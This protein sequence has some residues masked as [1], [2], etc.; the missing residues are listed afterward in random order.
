MCAT[1]SQ[2]AWLRPPGTLA[3]SLHAAASM[4]R[5]AILHRPGCTK[6]NPVFAPAAVW[7]NPS[8]NLTRY[9]K[10]RKPGLQRASYP[11]SP[12]LR[13]SPPRAG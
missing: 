12:G 8:L 10:R 9:G 11:C 13:R 3:T 7:P 1:A 5:E 2:L 4:P 6:R